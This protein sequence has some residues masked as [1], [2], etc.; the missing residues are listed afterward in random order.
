MRA[1]TLGADAGED[2]ARANTTARTTAEGLMKQ[3]RVFENS[4]ARGSGS[5]RDEAVKRFR[6][7][8]ELL[9]EGDPTRVDAESRLLKLAP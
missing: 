6:R 4:A 5:S 1:H 3:A 2:I 7:I 8:I 9:P